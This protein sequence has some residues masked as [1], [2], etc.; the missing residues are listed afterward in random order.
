M[1]KYYLARAGNFTFRLVIPAIAAGIIWGIFKKE[2]SE[3]TWIDQV[4]GGSF[5]ILILAFSELR[6]FITKQL[7][8]L[9]IDKR[10]SFMRNRGVLFLIMG[11]VLVLVKMFADKAI[12]FFFIAGASNVIAYGFEL[13]VAKYYRELH[14]LTVIANG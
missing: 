9:K 10:V 13:L 2:P 11:T 12:D 5:V 6:D 4:A 14:P 1:L 8:Q 3:M 7:T